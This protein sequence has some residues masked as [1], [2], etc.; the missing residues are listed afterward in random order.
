MERLER[1]LG[2]PRAVAIPL[3]TSAP[4]FNSC[5]MRRLEDRAVQ[6]RLFVTLHDAK[7]VTERAT[8]P[9]ADPGD[10]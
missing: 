5:L 2:D 6:K 1:A 7:S 4:C 9:T 3:L 10:A 8:P